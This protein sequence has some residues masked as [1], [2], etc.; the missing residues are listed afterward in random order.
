MKVARYHRLC[1][2]F[3]Q[4]IGGT[5]KKTLGLITLAVHLV[6][7]L[8]KP[9]ERVLSRTT[10]ERA[11]WIWYRSSSKQ[12]LFS[13]TPTTRSWLRATPLSPIDDDKWHI[14]N[15]RSRLHSSPPGL[16]IVTYRNPRHAAAPHAWV[17][18]SLPDY[19]III[20]QSYSYHPG[21]LQNGIA[22]PNA[23]SL[24]SRWDREVN[25]Q[26]YCSGSLTPA[27]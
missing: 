4:R 7:L 27:A 24:R 11:C 3:L 1:V 13:S 16:D 6:F 17:T 8:S 14:I 25:K 10:Y 26:S 22:R 19:G 5:D 21:R 12:W 2:S 15:N 9:W 18:R 20:R 23:A